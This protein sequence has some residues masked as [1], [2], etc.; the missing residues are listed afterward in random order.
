[1]CHEKIP[2]HTFPRC[3]FVL[4][5]DPIL[6]VRQAAR[7]HDGSRRHDLHVSVD[8]NEL[9]V[10]YPWD[11]S[12]VP[13]DSQIS[14][15]SMSPQ[16]L[17]GVYSSQA[18]LWAVGVI[19]Y[20]LLSTQKPFWHKKRRVVSV[21]GTIEGKIHVS[22]RLMEHWVCLLKSWWTGSCE[23]PIRLTPPSGRT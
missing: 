14:R 10:L 6:V 23:Y 7:Y 4:C 18:D 21:L 5:A 15:Y 1:M 2:C 16:V 3:L 13:I 12:H 9:S 20:M 22:T 8:Q 11:C 17:Q 19:A